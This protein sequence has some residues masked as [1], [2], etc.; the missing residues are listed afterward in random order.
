M[1]EDEERLII[2]SFCPYNTRIEQTDEEKLINHDTV[3]FELTC[4][5]NLKKFTRLPVMIGE[6]VSMA[7]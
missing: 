5:C 3:M 1:V 4:L 6:L 2:D 7:E